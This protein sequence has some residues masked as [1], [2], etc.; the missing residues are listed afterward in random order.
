MRDVIP[1][2]PAMMTT[3]GAPAAT[4]MELNDWTWE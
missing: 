4:F 3:R 2:P 1:D